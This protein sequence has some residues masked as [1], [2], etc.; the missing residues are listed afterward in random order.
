MK[1]LKLKSGSIAFLFLLQSCTIYHSRVSSAEEASEA[2]RKT[3]VTTKMDQKLFFNRVELK[4]DSIYGFANTNS[5]TAKELNKIAKP[6][7]EGKL[8]IPIAL[9]DVEKIQ[10]KDKALTILVPTV[11]ILG[12][13]IT[14]IAIE[15]SNMEIELWG[16]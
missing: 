14:W 9:K 13:G 4:P 2:A 10:L 7:T 15:I 11:L 8:M 3:K 12:A 1:Y 6:A 16:N 5:R